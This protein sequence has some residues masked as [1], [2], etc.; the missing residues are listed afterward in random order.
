MMVLIC[1]QFSVVK[2]Q[3]L[4]PANLNQSY[5]L[6]GFRRCKCYI[7]HESLFWVPQYLVC[8]MN[9]FWVVY[10]LEKTVWVIIFENIVFFIWHENVKQVGC[11]KRPLEKEQYN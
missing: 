4:V 1:Q 7:K 8:N 2:C 5:F 10:M 3:K 6:G 11:Q 9:M